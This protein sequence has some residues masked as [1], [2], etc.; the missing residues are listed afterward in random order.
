MNL[1]EYQKVYVIYLLKFRW[2]I[3]RAEGIHVTYWSMTY[4]IITIF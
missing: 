3:E 2:S 1:D 4:T